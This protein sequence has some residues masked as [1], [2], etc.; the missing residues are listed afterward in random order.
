MGN[1]L[2]SSIATLFAIF[3]PVPGSLRAQTDKPLITVEDCWTQSQA[4]P[5][6]ELVDKNAIKSMHRAD[7]LK[8]IGAKPRA[9]LMLA[10]TVS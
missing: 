6:F 10:Q 5:H 8:V 3:G 7:P 1:A 9:D 4:S 2:L